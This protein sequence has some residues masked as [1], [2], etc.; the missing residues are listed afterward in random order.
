MECNFPFIY[1]LYWWLN[2][3]FPSWVVIAYF[4]FQGTDLSKSTTA[5]LVSLNSSTS[6]GHVNPLTSL[7]T[8]LPNQGILAPYEKIPI[9]FRFSPRWVSIQSHSIVFYQWC[10]H[11]LQTKY[12][13]VIRLI[14]PETKWWHIGLKPV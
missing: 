10:L 6:T 11:A 1:Y 14:N 2:V 8:A 13:K 5:A 9:F 7:V 12:T 4:S 3:L